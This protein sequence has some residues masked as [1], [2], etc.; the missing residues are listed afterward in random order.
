MFTEL[1]TQVL[2]QLVERHLEFGSEW[3][4]E[5]DGSGVYPHIDTEMMLSEFNMPSKVLRG[6]ISSLIQ[7][8]AIIYDEGDIR[9]GVLPAIGLCKDAFYQIREAA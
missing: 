2:T 9:S 3:Y 7:K 1:E 4:T 5:D 6:V 8:D